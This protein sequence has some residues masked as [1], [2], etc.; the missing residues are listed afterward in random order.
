MNESSYC[1]EC[2]DYMFNGDMEEGSD[3]NYYC[4][5]CIHLHQEDEDEENELDETA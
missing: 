2:E 5:G 1:E 4:F 3:G